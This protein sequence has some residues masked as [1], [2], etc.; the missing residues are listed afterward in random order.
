[1]LKYKKRIFENDIFIQTAGQ[2][3]KIFAAFAVYAAG[4][5]SRLSP[6]RFKLPFSTVFLILIKER[7]DK[8]ASE[9]VNDIISAE[10]KA[11]AAEQEAKQKAEKIICDAKERADGIIKEAKNVAESKSKQIIEQANEKA[12]AVY[13]ETTSRSEKKSGELSEKGKQNLDKA[14]KAVKEYIIP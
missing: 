12:G 14:I 7:G 9:M 8:M 1:M 3:P 11:A 10:K 2:K 5:I 13:A 6:K 4:G